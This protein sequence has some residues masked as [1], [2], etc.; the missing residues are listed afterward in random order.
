[1]FPF[2]LEY[3][4]SLALGPGPHFLAALGLPCEDH[5]VSAEPAALHFVLG[6]FS[7]GVEIATC[8]SQEP[9]C[10]CLGK[11]PGPLM[12]ALDPPASVWP[13]CWVLPR[14]PSL[15]LSSQLSQRGETVYRVPG[16]KENRDICRTHVWAF[17][18]T[19][20]ASFQSVHFAL[21]LR[22]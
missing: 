10:A 11:I 20:S 15:A 22:Y 8:V 14:R 19:A 1:M 9:V 3:S 18:S 6:E 13:G 16:A 17:G 5:I 7:V 12:I 4:V 2:N 21:A